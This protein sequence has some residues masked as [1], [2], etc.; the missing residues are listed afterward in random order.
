MNAI[1]TCAPGVYVTAV[2][3]C[4]MV[5]HCIF[6]LV[7]SW[8]CVV[9]GDLM[10]REVN[11]DDESSNTSCYV[12]ESVF[13]FVIDLDFGESQFFTLVDISHL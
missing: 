3:G 13:I 12:A 2:C 10:Q 11:G 1:E 9:R 4:C 8:P 6:L 5:K 7:R